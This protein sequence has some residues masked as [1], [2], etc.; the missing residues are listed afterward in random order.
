MSR[1]G[2]ARARQA[3]AHLDPA[4]GLRCRGRRGPENDDES[5]AGS[6]Q[7]GPGEEGAV[8]AAAADGSSHAAPPVR[9]R[10]DPGDQPG[11]HPGQTRL[12]AV[13]SVRRA[14]RTDEFTVQLSAGPQTGPVLPPQ[15]RASQGAEVRIPGGL[16]NPMLRTRHLRRASGHLR[17][18]T[19]TQRARSCAQT[20]PPS[21]FHKC[22]RSIVPP[23][24]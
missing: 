4:L 23:E 12:W 21:I 20:G 11:A 14:C 2:R 5:R 1:A 22:L 17:L 16:A 6:A 19:P 13:P 10:R 15:M 3:S 24:A 8:T 9:L 7:G 18:S